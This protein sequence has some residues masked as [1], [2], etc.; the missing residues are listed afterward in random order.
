MKNKIKL[1]VL[2]KIAK[3]IQTLSLFWLRYNFIL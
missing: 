3:E 2:K 1:K